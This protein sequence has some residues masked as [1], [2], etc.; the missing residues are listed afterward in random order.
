MLGGKE[1]GDGLAGRECSGGWRIERCATM[2]NLYGILP[3]IGWNDDNY[4]WLLAD[5]KQLHF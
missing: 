2:R 4:C 3:E 5:R 1:R